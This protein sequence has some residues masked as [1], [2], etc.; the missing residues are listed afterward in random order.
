MEA[1]KRW[2]EGAGPKFQG[3]G[4]SCCAQFK[5]DLEEVKQKLD[6]VVSALWKQKDEEARKF[7][8]VIDSGV[9]VPLLVGL[10]GV[11]MGLVVAGMWK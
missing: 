4:S 8:I 1:Q 7:Q 2:R 11:M 10:F 6:S 9:V 3:D 5:D